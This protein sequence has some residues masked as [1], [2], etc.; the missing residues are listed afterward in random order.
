VKLYYG[1]NE[2]AKVGFPLVDIETNDEEE[3]NV[4]ASAKATVASTSSVSSPTT[5]QQHN[6]DNYICSWET[7]AVRRLLHEYGLNIKD[8]VGSGKSGL[9]LKGDLL[10]LIKSGSLEKKGSYTINAGMINTFNY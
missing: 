9:V 5:A 6:N 10:S 2:V 1:P 4:S 3:E 7:P 8:V